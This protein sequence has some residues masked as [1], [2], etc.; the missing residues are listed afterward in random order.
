M[1][2]YSIPTT[3][4]SMY[5]MVNELVRLMTCPLGGMESQRRIARIESALDQVP[6]K[7]Y[8]VIGKLIDRQLN[9]YNTPNE[10]GF[11]ASDMDQAILRA[12]G[13]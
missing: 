11:S 1:K 8:K 9:A 5:N 3:A 6:D 13:C 4:R 12:S 10:D 2:K 7:Y